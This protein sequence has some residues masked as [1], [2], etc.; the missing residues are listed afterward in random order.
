MCMKF[1]T[2]FFV[3]C[4]IF[5]KRS[6]RSSK[7]GCRKGYT[8]FGNNPEKCIKC[9]ALDVDVC[10]LHYLKNIT[11]QCVW[12]DEYWTEDSNSVNSVR[13]GKRNLKS[14]TFHPVSCVAASCPEFAKAFDRNLNEESKETIEWDRGNCHYHGCFYV[15]SKNRC[16]YWSIWGLCVTI[17]SISVVVVLPM[18]VGLS[19]CLKYCWSDYHSDYCCDYCCSHCCSYGCFNCCCNHCCN[20]CECCGCCQKTHTIISDDIVHVVDR[21]VPM[22]SYW[23]FKQ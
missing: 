18:L 17:V 15:K 1:Q 12:K 13:N 7:F 22:S 3:F 23:S 8:L 21:Q 10:K 20:R 2:L 11:L 19:C 9:N 4:L 16:S 14:K 5:G 6:D